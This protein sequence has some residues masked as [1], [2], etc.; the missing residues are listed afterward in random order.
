MKQEPL[1]SSPLIVRA[2]R[3]E[4]VNLAT[5]DEPFRGLSAFEQIG[6]ALRR[7]VKPLVA[8]GRRAFSS[9][10][11]R[12]GERAFQRV[13]ELDPQNETA[14]GH[15]SFIAQIREEEKAARGRDAHRPDPPQLDATAPF[16]SR[17]VRSL[18][19]TAMASRSWP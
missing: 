9:G 14:R 10:N 11:Y 4:E 16:R 17:R 1:A 5:G 7:L 12:S 19:R 2:A 8:K 18:T 3:Q 13:L 15:L 6:Q